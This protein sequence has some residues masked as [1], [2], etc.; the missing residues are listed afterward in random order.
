[1]AGDESTCFARLVGF[2]HS[3]RV[4]E[5]QPEPGNPPEPR[6]P[7]AADSATPGQ[8]SPLHHGH[9]WPVHLRFIDKLKRRNVGRV[10]VLYVIVGY[11]ALEV[12]EM[13]FR[14]LEMPA[15]A[16]RGVLLLLVLGFPAA[17]MFAWI[18]E[19]TPEGLKLSKE[20]H[21]DHSILHL[22]GRR[23]DRA[24]IAVLA[25]ALSYFVAD[26]FWLS[27]RASTTI[28]RT[29]RPAAT[30]ESHPPVAVSLVAFN[31][32]PHS[33]AVLPLVN[34]SGDK[35]QEYFSDGLS[36]ELLNA[37]SRINELQVA[38]HTS[39]FAFKG[40]DVKLATIAR[41]LNV[42]A[43]LEGSVQRSG[44]MV[45]ISCQLSS[46]V[47]GYQLWSQSYDRGVGDTL[48]VETDVANQVAQALKVKLLSDVS[49]KVEL[50]GTTN[51]DALDAYLRGIEERRNNTDYPEVKKS[52][53]SF[54]EAVRLDPSFA[55]A[56]AHRSDVEM[57]YGAYCGCLPVA[58][59]K[60][61]YQAAR[62]D[63]DSALKL[64]SELGE[65]HWALAQVLETADLDFAQASAEFERAVQLAPGNAQIL[66]ANAVFDVYMGNLER[67]KAG[68]SRAALLDPLNFHRW[69]LLA[70]VA[71]Y[72]GQYEESVNLSHKAL[73]LEPH[74]AVS[75]TTICDAYFQMGQLE[76]ARQTC[77]QQPD[78][79]EN[80]Q[81]LAVIYQRLGR[82]DDAQKMFDTLRH[83][84]GEGAAY[85]FAAIYAQWGDHAK[86][87]KWLEKAWKLRDPGLE[88]LKMDP[89]MKPLR[90]EPRYQA[91]IKALKFPD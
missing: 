6:T 89:L 82:H 76:R 53:A 60:K 90:N 39:S 5:E 15:W 88:Q 21:P 30:S 17:L 68:A 83:D 35:N 26:K 73:A 74:D 29:G 55:V 91:I 71:R 66:A 65:A 51:A 86:A 49:S 50:G 36:S 47:T 20:V 58:E 63:A 28:E 57:I 48:K 40:K 52:I 37:L 41:E 72:S 84:A 87:L 12:F 8:A 14:L 75:I 62:R 85:Q 45:R 10:A 38:A 79:W 1:M 78:N 27:K 31:P 11:L 24:I 23:L 67:A 54:G 13:F 70:N 43:I 4:G 42:A 25:I 32:P 56:Y 9:E 2:G 46:A 16:G 64:A 59:S 3:C 61:Y 77:E 69:R 81:L 19:V 18:Y 22:T 44:S 80:Q 7:A 34:L 33:I